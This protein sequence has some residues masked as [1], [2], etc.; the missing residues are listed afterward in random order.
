MYYLSEGKGF[1]FVVHWIKAVRRYYFG[2]ELLSDGVCWQAVHVHLD[3]GTDPLV[4]QELTCNDLNTALGGNDTVHGCLGERVEGLVKPPHKLWLELPATVAIVLKLALV[5]LHWQIR[6]LKVQGH[7]LTSGIPEDL[8]HKVGR[9]HPGSLGVQATDLPLVVVNE[10]DGLTL[11]VAQGARFGKGG[12][13]KMEVV[14][15][16][17]VKSGKFHRMNVVDKRGQQRM[18]IQSGSCVSRLR[19]SRS[20]SFGRSCCSVFRLII[21]SVK[22]AFHVLFQLLFLH[23]RLQSFVLDQDLSLEFARWGHHLAF[24]ELKSGSVHKTVFLHSL[25][26]LASYR[27]ALKDLPAKEVTKHFVAVL[28]HLELVAPITMVLK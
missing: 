27:I 3:V 13:L 23:L 9:V 17:L 15:L 2:P 22:L 1:L 7:Q 4:R 20:I 11:E 28:G 14:L 19:C 21:A 12:H 26:H 8:R 24:F 5:E 18:N 6:S 10:F 16:G 25:N